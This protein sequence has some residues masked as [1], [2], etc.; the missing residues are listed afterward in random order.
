MAPPTDGSLWTVESF[1]SAINGIAETPYETP[2][3]T[4]ARR[5][6]EHQ[7]QTFCANDG[8]TE[9]ALGELK[10]AALPCQGYRLAL[11]PGLVARVTAGAGVLS[12]TGFEPTL[13]TTEGGYVARA[14]GYWAP[15]GRLQYH[16]SGGFYLPR[17][18]V[19]PFG[20]AYTIDYDEHS[21]L[22]VATTD[23]LGNR[24]LATNDYRVLAPREVRDAN[25][26]RTAIGFDA[27]GMVVWTAVMGKE[28][29]REGDTPEHPTTR[30]EYHLQEWSQR[31]RPTYVRTSAREAH[32]YP[33]QAD[34]AP[35]QVSFT[36]SD[37]F[38]RV[39]MQKVHAEP[40]PVRNVSGIV[41]DRWV[42]SGRTVFNNK[43][44]PVKQY[45]P[46]FSATSEY[47][48]EAAVVEWGVTPV[49]YYDP[50]N[51]VVLTEYPNGTLSRVVFDAWRQ[52]TWD[53]ND[54]VLD[55]RWYRT[56]GEPDPNGPMPV[57]GEAR[58]AWLAAQHAGTPTITHLDSLG[59]A[60]RVEADLGP[61][62]PNSST[63]TLLATTTELDIEG[64]PIAITD[65]L[66][67][68][69]V[70]QQFD[71]LGRRI[72]V[73]SP[74]AG[75]RVTIADATGAPLRSWDSRGQVMHSRY[76]ALR[77]P[78]HLLLQQGSAGAQSV[79]TRTVY[80]ESLDG[81]APLQP[82]P[83]TGTTPTEAQR[84][85]LR[86]RSYLVFDGAGLAKSEEFD[87]KGNLRRSTRHL[88]SEFQEVPDW[89]TL[90]ELLG[91]TTP[92]NVEDAAASSLEPVTTPDV[93]TRFTTSTEYDALNRVVSSTAPDG[94]VSAPQ[95]NRAG[96]LER[97]LVTAGGTTRA[98][99]HSME[100]NEKGQ[101]LACEYSGEA[102]PESTAAYRTT[103]VYA[104]ETF[105]LQT[106]VTRR[107]S[108]NA[109]L[110]R[111]E[112]TYDPVGNIVE[113]LDNGTPVPIYANAKV[114]AH[115]SYE[116]DALYRLT[117][118]EGREHP[119]QQVSDVDAS[120][121]ELPTELPGPNDTSG[122]IRYRE[123]YQYDA[124]GNIRRMHHQPLAPR[125]EAWER[126]YL[127]ANMP[128]SGAT[129][130]SNRLLAT[131][132]P[133][134]SDGVFSARYH[135]ADGTD[136]SDPTNNAGLHGSMTQMPHLPSIH[137][138]YADRMRRCSTTV[139]SDVGT[140]YFTYDSSGQRVRKVWLH[141]GLREER[142]YLGGYEVYRRVR[143]AGT[144]QTLEA[145]RTTLHVVD[146][147]RR[148]AMVE[149]TLVDSV[150]PPG[151]RWRF[152]LDNHLGTAT[153]EVDHEGNVISYEEY[154]PY[155]T[156]AVRVQRSAAGFSQKRYRYTGKERDE[157][158]SLYYHGARYYA[159][160]LGRWT[161]TDPSG[162][163]DGPNLYLY[164]HNNPVN[165]HDPT[166]RKG[167]FNAIVESVKK[168]DFSPSSAFGQ[169]LAHGNYF[170]S[171]LVQDD[172]KLQTAQN[173]ATGT[174]ILA[175]SIATG[176]M[177]T[178]LAVGYGAS[179]GTA[180]AVGMVTGGA[181]MR[182]NTTAAATDSLSE[183]MK[184]AANPR[185]VAFDA[186]AG[187]A[188]GLIAEVAPAV[189]PKI[190]DK[191]KQLGRTR[192]PAG[193]PA[194]VPKPAA[195]PSSELEAVAAKPRAFSEVGSS[196][197][198]MVRAG[199]FSPRD[200]ALG[201]T[202]NAARE[203]LLKTFSGSATSGN[204][205]NGTAFRPDGMGAPSENLAADILRL[206]AEKVAATGGR[207]R[208]N[209]SGVSVRAALF[210]QGQV[211]WSVTSAELRGIIRSPQ[212]RALTDFYGAN[213]QI[214]PGAGS[215][216]YNMVSRNN[217]LNT[218]GAW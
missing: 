154:H 203:P 147:R 197:T 79:V 109:L 125:Y 89:S 74:D 117:L 211:G 70:E 202:F 29:A 36:Y 67:V 145:H 94:S 195:P 14:D 210:R 192:A 152:Q 73:T 104:P 76:D 66:G 24:I 143:G 134:D 205:L 92:A 15:G 59:R 155:G 161:A 115:A 49:I 212:L 156:S 183:S 33:N 184:A 160:W 105:R 168:R 151:R 177:A 146:D 128:E 7:Q 213:G 181:Y 5:L 91:A 215:R 216:M 186:A 55:S 179:A 206:S 162:A 196:E 123:T 26:N 139:G 180:G 182:A 148:V 61:T 22:A 62:T 41:E 126:R 204:Q 20:H 199:E 140:V 135:Y 99:V 113:V 209:L 75:A 189:L 119:G 108:N 88:A 8:T 81:N 207:I 3:T 2:V 164:V 114:R 17:R 174:A 46:F 57:S 85:N 18:A 172:K 69:T 42:G 169:E 38:G 118:A 28:G 116:Y 188:V 35:R 31:E 30:F 110:Q 190:L 167:L 68:R 103:Y 193:E 198:R 133:G 131:S 80:G 37:G 130:R 121:G 100:Y 171:S 165:G 144:A 54:T 106:M 136:P 191:A 43:G 45:E 159:P 138:D 16:G 60:F 141:S 9:L 47:E 78:T 201:R 82:Q 44:N 11:T 97:M 178:H 21:L 10:S 107:R 51:R 185:A 132:N 175:G 98:A 163:D 158:T 58:A 32:Y 86:G 83:S 56:R 12:A 200:I 150:V 111:L 120:P 34:A 48:D 129:V 39:V 4:R 77:R 53:L 19:D 153:L 63:H 93:P 64:N 65:A 176:G 71:V 40:G 157:E 166:G 102:G 13:L 218:R 173:V 214:L 1:R 217:P 101:R 87:F 23:P 84:L 90:P 127:Y 50:L 27:L 72:A 95:Y 112:Y 52:E 96:L 25:L 170:G 187:A 124:V 122:M 149:N 6:V 137:W 142:V 194:A 208:F